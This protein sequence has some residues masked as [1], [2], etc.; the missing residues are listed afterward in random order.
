MSASHMPKKPIGED[1]KSLIDMVLS[2]NISLEEEQGKN[3]KL[4]VDLSQATCAN[5]GLKKDLKRSQDRGD[6]L[7]ERYLQ[8]LDKLKDV[9]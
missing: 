7:E 8:L 9:L 6:Q 5:D 1:A 3:K 2:L 4:L